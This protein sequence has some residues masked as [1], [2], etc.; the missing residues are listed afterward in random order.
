MNKFGSPEDRNF[1]LV[2]DSINNLVQE[3]P[4]VLKRRKTGKPAY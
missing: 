4:G 2:R 1:E 3:A